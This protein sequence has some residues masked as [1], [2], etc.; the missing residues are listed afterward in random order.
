M[1]TDTM[2]RGESTNSALVRCVMMMKQSLK[3]FIQSIR[4]AKV[5][6][7]A[8]RIG[9]ERFSYGRKYVSPRGKNANL[10]LNS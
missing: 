10:I 3:Y 5:A 9:T 4:K 7:V 6:K 1:T 2:I 8:I